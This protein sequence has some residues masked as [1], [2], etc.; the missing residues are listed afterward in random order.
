MKKQFDK[1]ASL[2]EYMYLFIFSDF[3]FHLSALRLTKQ[4]LKNIR[5]GMRAN[6]PYAIY[7]KRIPHQY[8]LVCSLITRYELLFFRHPL[9][10]CFFF[11]F[12]A[13]RYILNK[14]Q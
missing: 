2:E 8:M 5:A 12:F 7:K 11:F 9:E 6:G 13:L 4:H 3:F 10:R 1:Y 14:N